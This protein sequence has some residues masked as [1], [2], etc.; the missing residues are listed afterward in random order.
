[1]ELT[2]KY[3]LANY[4]MKNYQVF[5]TVVADMR[6]NNTPP[7][8]KEKIAS[9]LKRYNPDNLLIH[10][11][12]LLDGMY[13]HLGDDV[14]WKILAGI[15]QTHMPDFTITDLHA[16]DLQYLET[17][18]RCSNGK[19]K[20]VIL[21]AISSMGDS[22][23]ERVKI[24]LSWEIIQTYGHIPFRRIKNS[25]TYHLTEQIISE[26]SDHAVYVMI[27]I[28]TQ[29]RRL[30]LVDRLTA[31][32]YTEPLQTGKHT[33]KMELTRK[34]N[35]ANYLMR[36]DKVF[37]TVAADI[38]A[39]TT[40]PLAQEEVA[41][42]LRKYGADSLLKHPETLVGG[43]S[44]YL[45]DDVAWKILLKTLQK[46]VPH[47]K[48]IDIRA[49]DLEKLEK[50]DRCIN[51]K[52][53][54]VIMASL[55]G[56]REA[57][58]QRVKLLLSWEIVKDHGHIPF[59]SVA[60]SSP[61][62]LT[63]QIFSTYFHHVVFVM[64]LIFTQIRRLDLIDDL[65]AAACAEPVQIRGQTYKME[66]TRKFE[67]ANYLMRYKH[68]FA[69]VLADVRANKTLNEPQQIALMLGA[70]SADKLLKH[71]ETLVDAMTWYLREPIAW[72]ILVGILQKHWIY[73]NVVD[74][75][76]HGL[77]KLDKY[78]RCNNSDIKKVILDAISSMGDSELERVKLLLSWEIVKG[79]GHIPLGCLENSSRRRLTKQIII[80]YSDH[81]AFVMSLIFTQIQRLD[82]VG[83]LD[84]AARVQCD[85]KAIPDRA[86][87]GNAP[88]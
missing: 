1:M 83:R 20:K 73:F 42:V 58:L 26:H 9:L 36:H 43:M 70:R 47:F 22:E 29:I 23:L 86:Q 17:Y 27:L 37:A 32:A 60:N 25:S 84:A 57:E 61:W 78:D 49:H 18:D 15:L 80:Q 33:C 71:P 39:S 59:E 40:P 21:H 41:S 76:A 67:M 48:S 75:H 35:L 68:A 24:L 30:D 11:E 46:H 45:G 44:W 88:R 50:Y 7:L 56:L 6:V 66:L 55:L 10:P 63:E 87:Q 79:Y 53:K 69:T 64:S 8:A 31:V 81:A 72:T 2:F 85:T 19:I 51:S 5:D 62:H 82:L 16:H 38:R 12:T 3:T 77:E 54:T 28:F 13:R 34:F 14:T 4:L 65:T 74:L 52:I